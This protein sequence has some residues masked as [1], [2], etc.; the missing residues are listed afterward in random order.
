MPQKLMVMRIRT[1]IGFL[2]WVE[3]NRV[4]YCKVMD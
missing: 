4:I 3:G 1:G 2:F